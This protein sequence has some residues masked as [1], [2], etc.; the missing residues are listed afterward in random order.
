MC[1]Y[2]CYIDGQTCIYVSFIAGQTVGSNRLIFFTPGI[3][4]AKQK[5]NLF[6]S[7][8]N[9]RATPGTSANRL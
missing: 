7:F 1:I 3:T 9:P 5:R 4:Y 2:V 8:K 6:F